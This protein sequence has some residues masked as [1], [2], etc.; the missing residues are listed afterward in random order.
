MIIQKKIIKL[1][2]FTFHTL[3]TNLHRKIQKFITDFQ[4]INIADKAC[5]EKIF[6]IIKSFEKHF[7]LQD[8]NPCNL[9]G[10]T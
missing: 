5:K 2:H 1:Q 6:K 7:N 3:P 4:N 9:P 10:K 8:S